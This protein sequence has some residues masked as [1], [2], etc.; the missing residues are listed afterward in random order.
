M[1]S[2]V[3]TKK[4]CILPWIH[5]HVLPDATVIPCCMSPYDSAYG[6]GTTESLEQIWNSGKFKELRRKM[7][8]DIPSEGCSRC[9]N[10]E[11]SGFESPREYFNSVFSNHL[12]V[13]LKTNANG[14]IPATSFKYI[15]IRFSNL[16]NFKCRGCGPTLSSSWFDDYQRLYN[17]NS[18]QAKVKSVSANAPNFWEEIKTIIPQAERIYF[19]GGEP[20]ITKEHFEVL[21]LLET[22][23]MFDTTLAYNTN[24][25]HLNYSGFN[26]YEI[27]SKFKIVS[28]GISIDDIGKRAEYFRHGTNWKVIEQNLLK[29]AANYS[30]VKCYVNCTVNIMN[31]FYLPEIYNYLLEQ[32]VISTD[33][34][35]INLLLDPVELRIQVLPSS[36]K[37]KV[38]TKLKNFS[39]LL[40]TKGEQYAKAAKDFDRILS[41]LDEADMSNQLPLFREN[42][43]KLD[44]L[45]NE[46]FLETFPELS[47]LMP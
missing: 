9:Y 29:I 17:R 31:V 34:F 21:K 19:G 1:T 42:T 22:L 37:D 32:K 24:L 6:N 41:F 25:S 33:R 23:E 5:L 15:D 28:L 10:L 35:N 44:E 7:M 30:H 27:W 36:L 4:F 39:E 16:C 46:S 2:I 14:S 45:R 20:L 26:L 12:T 11:S 13:V 43:K 3:R 8:D 47:E 38:R 18:D 40:L